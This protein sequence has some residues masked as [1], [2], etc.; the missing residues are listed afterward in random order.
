MPVRLGNLAW[1]R[2][3][4]SDMFKTRDGYLMFVV[5]TEPQFLTFS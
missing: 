2:K 1:S 3:P 4:T 5:N